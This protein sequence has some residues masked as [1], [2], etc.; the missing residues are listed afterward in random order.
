MKTETNVIT[1]ASNKAGTQKRRI[2]YFSMEIALEAHIPTYSGGLGVLA[3]DTIRSAADLGIPMVAVSLLYRKGYFFQRLDQ[4]GRQSEETVEWTPGDHLEELPE[5]ATVMIEERPV[6]VRPW[7][8]QVQ[9]V[10]GFTVPV[11][12][13]DTDLPEN[14]DE[15]RTWTDVLYG[16]DRRYR[17]CQEVILGVGGVRILEALG[18]NEI[19]RFHMNEGHSALLTLELLRR[20]AKCAGRTSVSGPDI[21]AVREKC[22]FTTHTPVPAGHDQFPIELAIRI[23]GEDEKLFDLKDTQIIGLLDRILGLPEELTT[24]EELRRA[25]STLNMTLLALNISHYVN[26]VAKKHTEITSLMFA[27]YTIHS[28]TNGVHGATWTSGPFQE[29]YDRYIPGWR[30]D[31]FSL[32]Y[33]LSIPRSKVWDAHAEAKKNLID[34]VNR[35]TNAGMSEEVFTIGFARRAA[36]YK[37]ADLLFADPARLREVAGGRIQIVYA[38]KAHPQDQ[39]GKDLIARIWEMKKALAGSI[40]IAYLPNYDMT[41][42]KMITSGVDLWLNTPQP[43]MEA[44]GTS[45]MKAALNGVPSLSILDGWWIEGCI[46][47]VTGWAIGEDTR[48]REGEHDASRDAASLYDKLQKT[49]VPLFY[50]NRTGFGDVML[51]CMALNGSFFNTHRMLQQYVMN[52][53][54]L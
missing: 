9:G 30:Q 23:I 24:I 32:R 28:I 40:K 5:R 13:L 49:I 18:H 15:D 10:T 6:S 16:G 27:K 2:A 7:L 11:Y 45:G 29:L 19:P 50:D 43:P 33:A 48:N 3:G 46:E 26:G 31:M 25:T 21:E 8:Y 38:G 47:G 37:R 35:E 34:Y 1:G 44:S 53:Y 12:L 36:T 51:H 42:G 52:A 54:F 17:L 20:E 39:G 41:V 22:I 14:A 4:N